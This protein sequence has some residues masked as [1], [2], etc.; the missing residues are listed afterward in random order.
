MHKAPLYTESSTILA[1]MDRLRQSNSGLFFRR[2]GLTPKFLHLLELRDDRE[3]PRLVAAKKTSFMAENGGGCFFYRLEGQDRGFY[4]EVLNESRDQLIIALPA[5]IFTVWYRKASRIPCPDSAIIVAAPDQTG[6]MPHGRALDISH[7]GARL[8]GPF[9]A[10]LHRGDTIGPCSFSLPL[11][12]RPEEVLTFTIGEAKVA[13][14]SPR[15]DGMREVGISFQA[16][17]DET[18]KIKSY[19]VACSREAT[20]RTNPEPAAK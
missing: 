7:G 3:A 19:I 14:S 18:A 15:T 1:E 8:A 4:G 6:S 5:K 10:Q 13:W 12:S 11:L 16:S 2:P 17:S 20:S 9:P